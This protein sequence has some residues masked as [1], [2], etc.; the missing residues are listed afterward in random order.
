META[1]WVIAGSSVLNL[2]VL[3]A[4]AWFT[5]GIWRETQT[6][7]LRTEELARQ[8]RDAFRMQIVTSY[9]EETRQSLQPAKGSPITRELRAARARALARFL[10]EAFPDHWPDVEQVIVEVVEHMME[11]YGDKQPPE[12]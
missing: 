11:F 9:L 12:A 10:E 8:S 6:S 3:A 4:Y 5:W 2:A 1:T 7:A